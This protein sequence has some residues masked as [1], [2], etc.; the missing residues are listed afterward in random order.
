MTVK[1]QQ[2]LEEYLLVDS[3]EKDTEASSNAGAGLT[4]SAHA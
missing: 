2:S 1:L 4:T 3:L